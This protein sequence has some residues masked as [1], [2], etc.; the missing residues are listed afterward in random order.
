MAEQKVADRDLLLKT[1]QNLIEQVLGQRAGKPVNNVIEV[2][3]LIYQIVQIVATQY[4]KNGDTIGKPIKIEL[5][6]NIADS[7]IEAL[8][9]RKAPLITKDTYDQAKAITANVSILASY[10]DGVI[11]VLETSDEFKQ[12]ET[13]AKKKC[14]CGCFG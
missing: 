12:V 4:Q 6:C 1:A 5:A 11:T 8:Y 2:I 10:F 14:G 9:N 7:I 13:F 3:A